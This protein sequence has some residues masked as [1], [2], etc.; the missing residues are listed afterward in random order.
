MSPW[1]PLPPTK[2]G[3]SH[4]FPGTSRTRRPTIIF[5]N[6]TSTLR[7]RMVG[8]PCKHRVCRIAQLDIREPHIDR[9]W[10]R[11]KGE[12]SASR[13]LHRLRRPLTL[14]VPQIACFARETVSET[15]EIV[16][17]YATRDPPVS[18]WTGIRIIR[19]RQR[20]GDQQRPL[21][22]AADGRTGCC[23]RRPR[24][25]AGRSHA[26]GGQARLGAAL[27]SPGDRALVCLG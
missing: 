3:D 12:R 2:G 17:T 20:H 9:E 22:A 24:H 15:G 1:S 11:L 4:S 27:V 7:G 5:T 6:P 26:A 16:I 23:C 19:R 13:H 25:H 14:N 10:H 21:H 18:L 8:T